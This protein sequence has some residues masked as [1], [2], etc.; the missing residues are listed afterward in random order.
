MSYAFG[1]N[2]RSYEVKKLDQYNPE[3]NSLDEI[4]QKL[5]D[6]INVFEY[7]ESMKIKLTKDV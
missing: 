6:G 1:N 7:K 4:Y 5:L 2:E 3:E